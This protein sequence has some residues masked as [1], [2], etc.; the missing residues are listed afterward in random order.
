MK[1]CR[2]GNRARRYARITRI[3]LAAGAVVA[4]WQASPGYAGPFTGSISATW[5]APVLRGNIVDGATGALTPENDTTTAACNIGCVVFVNGGTNTVA[6][7]NGGPPPPTSSLSF[8]GAN[9]S[10][11]TPAK[12]VTLGQFTYTNGTSLDGTGIFGATLTL[13][14]IDQNGTVDDTKVIPLSIVT[15]INDG[16]PAQNTDFVQFPATQTTLSAVSMNVFEGDTATFILRGEIVGDPTLSLVDL[17]VAP[18]SDNAGFVGT[19]RP[20]PEPGT[21]ALLGFGLTGLSL[22]R[23]RFRF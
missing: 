22:A 7:G 6:W 8:T 3:A 5:S 11:Q 21:L 10:S 19:G 12:L 2:I 15:T 18:G 14:L 23:R 4:S 20:V 16:T 1:E 13:K 17:I 9:F